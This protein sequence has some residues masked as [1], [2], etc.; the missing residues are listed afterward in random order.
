MEDGWRGK[1]FRKVRRLSR[2]F[3]VADGEMAKSTSKIQRED[4]PAHFS[5]RLDK[6]W[7]GRPRYTV[8]LWGRYTE[9]GKKGK[10]AG[11]IR[12]MGVHAH[13]SLPG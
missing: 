3:R 5:T 2:V 12:D 13:M 4:S 9:Q 8:D 6:P 7:M 1:W 10:V 11:S